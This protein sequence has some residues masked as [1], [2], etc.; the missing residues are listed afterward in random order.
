MPVFCQKHVYVAEL[1][2][3]SILWWCDK[4]CSAGGVAHKHAQLEWMVHQ[5]STGCGNCPASRATSTLPLAHGVA[6]LD[7]GGMHCRTSCKH[8]GYEG[9]L[10][11]LLLLLLKDKEWRCEHNTGH[12]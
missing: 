2:L 1:S 3:V 5:Q 7:I 8:P 12:S 4:H 10:L 6:S 9:K 11:L